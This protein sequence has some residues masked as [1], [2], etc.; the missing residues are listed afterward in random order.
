MPQIESHR[1]VGDPWWLV[2]PVKRLDHAKSRL[3]GP[4]AAHRGAFAL[5]FAADT[6]A[7]ALRA[8]GVVG[9]LAVTDD[10]RAA[11]TLQHLGAVVVP[12]VPDAGLNAALLHG[13]H[14]VALRHPGTA[15]GALSADLPALR[16][17]EL[18]LALA[19]AAGRGRAV[20]ADAHGD[21]TTVY[22]AEAGEV[23]HPAFGPASLRAHVAVG[24]HP[25]TGQ[26]MQSLRRDVDTAADL[27]AAIAIGV[28]PATAE[29]VARLDRPDLT[30]FSAHRPAPEA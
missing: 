28:G 21:G 27:A 30:R 15:I 29:V 3:G 18:A 5:A 8:P 13:A 25:L 12:D 2:V 4:A 1:P 20:V 7:A 6:V 14:E 22:L 17:A 26:D 19:R 16:P 23:F 10:D 9:V 11:R 24:A